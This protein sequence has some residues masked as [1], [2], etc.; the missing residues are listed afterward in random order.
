MHVERGVLADAPSRLDER[1]YE[2][3][4]GYGRVG[5]G[6]VRPGG[7]VVADDSRVD[8][9]VA[10]PDVRLE[11]AVLPTLMKWVAPALTSSSTAI[12]ADGQPTPVEVALIEMPCTNL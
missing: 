10:G 1:V 5:I 11:P 3:V 6:D 4:V 7:P 12:E 9:D 8:D 2:E